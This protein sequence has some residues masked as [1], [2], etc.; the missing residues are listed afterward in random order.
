MTEV[1][2][3]ASRPGQLIQPKY[4]ADIDG[5]RAI[6]VLSVVGF[7]AFPDWIRGGFI[8]V[9][10]F[11]VISGYLISTIIFENLERNSFS[12]FEF[13]SRRI[14]RIFP[15]LLLVLIALTAFGWFALFADE[16]KQLG[17]HIAAGAGFVS[18]IVLWS[19]SGYFDRAAEAKPLLHLWSLG[20]EEQFYIIWPLLLW[21]SRKLRFNFL[22]ITAAIASISFALNIWQIHSDVIATF[23]SPQT[24]FWE[25]LIGSGL[26][27]FTLFKQSALQ[28][29]R[30]GNNDLQSCVGIVLLAFAVIAITKDRAFPGWWALLPTVG[31]LLIISAGPQAWVNR[32]VLANRVMVW[33][34]LISFPL[35][36]WHWPLLTTTRIVESKALSVETRFAAVLISIALSW[37]TY[38][39]IERPIRFGRHTN[40]K[41]YSLALL[42]LFIGCFGYVCYNRDGFPRAGYAQ[43][44]LNEYSNY[45]NNFSWKYFKEVGIPDKYRFDCDFYDIPK[46]F[47]GEATRVPRDQINKSCYE[48]NFDKE[49]AAFIWGDSHAQQ[50]YYGLNNNLPRDWQLMI[51]AS[52]GCMPDATVQEDSTTDFCTRTN[53]FAL[54]TIKETKPKVVLV[55]QSF[56]HDYAKMKSTSET[57]KAMGVPKVVF[58][59]PAPHWE[60][61]LPSIIMRRLWQR[62]PERTYLGII[63]DEFKLNESLKNEFA[64]SEDAYF[65]DLIG[66]FCNEYGCL[67]R[68][69]NDKKT[70]I[71]SWDTCHLTPIASDYLAKNLL[72]EIVFR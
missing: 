45:F 42:T 16:Y 20:I 50:L 35:Y 49:N 31:A 67:T 40:T 9:D 22:L 55:A 57:L 10:I 25:L 27:Y 39:F 1:T 60:Q 29:F 70:G 61:P 15:A 21:S 38:R 30:M 8:G 53:W 36:L 71:T 41:V 23:Y 54:K 48:R 26:A 66:L 4:R 5:L 62:T 28:K 14:R 34:G 17:K 56:A 72:S 18:N 46:F 65:A 52:S 12:F 6:A 37:A 44:E 63:E 69:G 43:N 3:P 32:T 58:T 2:P 11:F 24:R 33:F 19:E 47:A 13:Y 7:H 68:I 51:V 59:G 64:K